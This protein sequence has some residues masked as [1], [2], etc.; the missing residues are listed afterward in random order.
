MLN[1]ISKN[2]I[3]LFFF[4]IAPNESLPQSG[5]SCAKTQFKYKFRHLIFHYSLIQP[6]FFLSYSGNEF[7]SG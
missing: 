7:S 2:H 5:T 4:Y 6:L 1:K 3:V